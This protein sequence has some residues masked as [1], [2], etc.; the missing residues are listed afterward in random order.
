MGGYVYRGSA[1]R[2]AAGEALDAQRREA[3]RKRRKKI[4]SL[5]YERQRFSRIDRGIITVK[6]K[7]TRDVHEQQRRQAS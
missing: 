4:R 1:K 3:A 6:W 2:A 7:A 5:A